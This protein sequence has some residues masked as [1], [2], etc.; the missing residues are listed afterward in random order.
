VDRSADREAQRWVD[1]AFQV[2]APDAVVVSWWSYS[3]AMW[4]AQLVAG[5]RPD[6]DIIDDRTRLDRNLGGLHHVID[7]NLPS[8]PVYVIRADPAEIADLNEHYRL[9]YEPIPGVSLLAR[10]VGPRVS[11]P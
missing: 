6:I 11:V 1:Q 4:Y 8:R 7:A 3:T 10:V 9:D 2:M 5:Q